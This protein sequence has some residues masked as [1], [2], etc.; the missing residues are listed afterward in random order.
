MMEQD[1]LQ[2][3]LAASQQQN[4]ELQAQLLQAAQVVQA[5]QVMQ[6]EIQQLR[7]AQL[8]QSSLPPSSSSSSS[9]LAP[10]AP[11]GRAPS[12]S[13]SRIDLKPMQPSA[14]HGTA[15]SNADQWLMEV[16]RYFAVASLPD[17][18]SRRVPFASTFLKDNASTWYASVHTEIVSWAD[19]KQR[20]LQRFRPLAASRMARAAIRNLK[21]RFKVASYSAEFQK[22][23]QHISDMSV[24]DQIEFYI[25][26]LQSHLAMEVDRDAPKTLAA[27]MEC[28]QRVELML[29]SR[30]GTSTFG[31]SRSY[32]PPTSYHQSGT[33]RSEDAM[34]LSALQEA[35]EQGRPQEETN[36]E[37]SASDSPTTSS[38][39]LRLAAM[40]QRGGGRSNFG[41]GRGPTRGG[42]NTRVPNLSQEEYDKLSSEGKCF[43]CRQTG[44]LARNCSSNAAPSNQTSSQGKN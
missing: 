44:H 4:Q 20:F 19:F 21:Q 26:G 33:G 16:E 35:L 41:R 25:S 12:T 23:L 11:P 1:L 43:R 3:Q 28:A 32:L 9:F 34:D 31:R 38:I 8:Q 39:L 2:E 5:M 7:A 10:D 17:A 37:S 22:H 14:F 42:R 40:L 13:I 27:A 36:N 15:S 24:A 30:R 29:A 6:A 18:D